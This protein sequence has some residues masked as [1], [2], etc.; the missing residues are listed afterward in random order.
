[1]DKKVEKG[2]NVK[3]RDEVEHSSELLRNKEK[4][5]EIFTKK[6]AVKKEVEIEAKNKINKRKKSGNPNNGKKSTLFSQT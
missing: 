6:K 4:I 2:K 5:S 1:M 3:S